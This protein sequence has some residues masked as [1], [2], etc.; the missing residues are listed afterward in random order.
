MA[1]I[2][3][4]AYQR[5]LDRLLEENQFD[6]ASRHARHILTSYPKNLKATR[7]LG[8]ALFAA[9]RWEE[10]IQM[11]RRL[12]GARPHDF[13]AHSLLAQAYQRLEAYDKAIWHAERVSEQQP[14]NQNIIN[15]RRSLYGEHRG[16][17]AERWQPTISGLAQQHIRSNSLA[18][19]LAVL[20]DGLKRHPHHIGLLLLQAQTLWLTGRRTEAAETA[21]E[22][23]TRLPYAQTANRIMTELWLS[24]QRP[25]DARLYLGRIEELDPYLAWQLASG[26]PPDDSLLMI[27][28]LDSGA[29][30]PGIVDLDWLDDLGEMDTTDQEQSG[31]DAS[32]LDALFGMDES[33]AIAD[34]RDLLPEVELAELF[35]EEAA[36][37]DES[38]AL[39][40]LMEARGF[41][42][43]AD[44]I[45]AEMPAPD[46]DE[47]DDEL[48]A[49]LE[50]LD[51]N[52]GDSAWLVD[53][54]QRDDVPADSP[55]ETEGA[56]EGQWA[57]AALHAEQ[58]DFDLFAEDEQLQTLLGKVSE[59]QPIHPDD[60][61]FWLDSSD[62]ADEQTDEETDFPELAELE[63]GS[64]GHSWLDDEDTLELIDD[65]QAELDGDDA[66][67]YIDW[68][69]E[70]D[71]ADFAGDI[72]D[73]GTA[74]SRLSTPGDVKGEGGPSDETARAWGLKD[75]EQL[76]DFVEEGVDLSEG[77]AFP[78][79]LNAMVPGL[80]H[81]G[82]AAADE[83]AAPPESAEEFEWLSDIVDEEADEMPAVSPQPPAPSSRHFIFSKPPLWLIELQEASFSSEVLTAASLPRLEQMPDADSPENA[84]ELN[85]DLLELEGSFDFDAPT[86][87]IVPVRLHETEF[88]FAP[89]DL[90][91]FNFDSPT[92]E[93]TP[94]G[95]TE[96]PQFDELG[97][98]DE[99]FDPDAESTEKITAASESPDELDFDALD[100]DLA[101]G[102]G[103]QPEWLEYDESGL[104]DDDF[105]FDGTETRAGRRRDR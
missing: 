45:D 89:L 67:D 2:S 27:E 81:D 21:L 50:Q 77:E 32:G 62:I 78:D 57:A 3:L 87:K 72:G 56:P 5:Q 100:D 101:D 17:D 52:E 38:A 58:D 90:D 24:E 28:E 4:R 13:Q 41:L 92:E 23:L 71:V 103:G 29:Q 88:N 47:A 14:A 7:Q 99:D 64:L 36:A 30:Q 61:E 11:L 34:L 91:D 35:D 102:N 49:M 65:W 80:D 76:A 43:K 8:A 98:D 9:S 84:A 22:V 63:S 105:D 95:A 16:E 83:G 15:L 6:E 26:Q 93:I 97:L 25:S 48:A 46:S 51:A 79:W 73:Y 18:D 42:E 1:K 55:P 74:T 104:D 94:P 39:I 69:N 54:Q 68:L 53:M 44:S 82:E 19:A 96:T 37:D 10:A 31:I 86:E 85:F 12:L 66:D 33:P 60:I 75:A 20:T 59:T 40:S 70:D